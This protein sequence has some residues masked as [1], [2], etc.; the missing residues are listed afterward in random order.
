MS[1]DSSDI[2]LDRHV[3]P[4][5]WVNPTSLGRYHLVVIGAG[6]AGLVAA[7]GA[8]GLGAKVALIEKHRLGGDC[9]NYG[10]VPSKALLKSARVAATVRDAGEFGVEVPAGSR[11]D[12]GAVMERMRRLRASLAPHDSAERFRGLGVDVFFGAG[13]F[14]SP[15]TIDVGGQSLRFRR[16]LIATGGRAAIPDIPGLAESGFVTNEAVFSLASLPRRLMV[17]GAGPIGCELAQAFARFGSQVT[18]IAS[19]ANVLPKEDADAA[20]IVEASLRRDGVEIFTNAHAVEVTRRTD[21][22]LV[23][24]ERGGESSGLETRAADELLVAVGRKPNVDELELNLAGVAF[25][26]QFGVRVD[27]HFRTTNRRIFA[28][29]DVCSRF[30]F[31]HAADAM[32]RIVLQNALFPGQ[33]KG[34]SLVI[35]RCTYTDPEV[36]VVGLT[37]AEACERGVAVD[38]LVEEMSGNDRAVVDGE[39]AGFAKVLLKRGTDRILGATIVASNAGDMLNEITLAMTAKLGLCSLAKTIHSYPTQSEIIK[40]LADQAQR[41]RL[42]PFVKRLF[43]KWFAWTS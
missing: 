27:D 24:I 22:K 13:R 14:T 39:T 38:V 16:A 20:R 6:P 11:V 30:Q 9:L 8:A 32:A 15:D 34:S 31:T 29:G 7:A 10:C 40:R 17:L 41:R 36:A 4:L 43:E 33:G 35:P 26:S 2:D 3:A 25:D 12:F 18:L 28:A 42:T 1:G 21:E 37:E 19:H 23:K 5:D